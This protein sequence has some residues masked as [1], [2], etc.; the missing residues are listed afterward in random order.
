MTFLKDLSCEFYIE[1]VLKKIQMW[2]HPSWSIVCSCFQF[3]R[4]L[5]GASVWRRQQ[6]SRGKEKVSLKPLKS[7][8]QNCFR[9]GSGKDDFFQLEGSFNVGQ[10]WLPVLQVC[11]LA[12][13]LVLS[14]KSFSKYILQLWLPV[15]QVCNLAF[16]LFLS[17]KYFSK[18]ILQLWLPVL[19]VPFLLGTWLAQL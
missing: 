1:V 4:Q 7:H 2:F 8:D 12:F 13:W 10:L 19:Q 9:L 14:F 15:I 17:F 16:W 3:C 18:Y 5:L 6:V 11:N